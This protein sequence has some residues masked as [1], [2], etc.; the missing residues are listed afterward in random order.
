MRRGAQDHAAGGK[1]MKAEGP[2]GEGRD[3]HHGDQDEGDDGDHHEDKDGG[4]GEVEDCV[5]ARG[6]G[7]RR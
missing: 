5:T 6:G 3:V 1:L 7:C 4:D 2:D